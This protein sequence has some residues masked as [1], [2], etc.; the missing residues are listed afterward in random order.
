VI[1]VRAPALGRCA[2]FCVFDQEMRG[3]LVVQERAASLH[4]AA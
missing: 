1:N 4:A 2:F 3:V